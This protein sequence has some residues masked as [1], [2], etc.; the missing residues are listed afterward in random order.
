M[1]RFDSLDRNQ[2]IRCGIALQTVKKHIQMYNLHY[3]S[4]RKMY[5]ATTPDMGQY[6]TSIAQYALAVSRSPVTLFIP[7]STRNDCS[8]A[9]RIYI[10]LVLLQCSCAVDP[11][12][13]S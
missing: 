12:S 3:L 8:I 10:T 6:R 7:V 13:H 1:L 4:L 5:K 2:F 11:M 9:Y